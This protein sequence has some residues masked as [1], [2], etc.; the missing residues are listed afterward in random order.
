MRHFVAVLVVLLLVSCKSE[1]KKKEEPVKEVPLNERP[2]PPNPNVQSTSVVGGAHYICPQQ[3]PEGNSATA[4]TCPKC[5]SQLSHNQGYHQAQNNQNQPNNGVIN[6]PATTPATNTG[7]N[8]NG[9]YHYTCSN[10]CA[11]GS[12]T[13]GNCAT[14]GNTLAHNQAYHS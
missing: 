7:T 11:G 2:I 5:Q 1:D 4:G 8:A 6:Q 13:A 12:A 10:G 14:C 9:V 3:H